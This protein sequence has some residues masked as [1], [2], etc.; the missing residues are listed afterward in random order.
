VHGPRV[1][2]VRDLFHASDSGVG[3]CG[4]GSSA[5][6]RRAVVYLHT[7]TGQLREVAEAFA[8]V[9]AVARVA[10]AATLHGSG[11]R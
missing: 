8:L 11:I 4:A 5:M 6:S 2:P 1:R 9:T 3:S 10:A 7:R